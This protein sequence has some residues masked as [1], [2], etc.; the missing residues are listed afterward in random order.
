MRLRLAAP[1]LLAGTL[2]LVYLAWAPRA[3]DLAAQWFRTDLFVHEGLTIW[4]GHW[5]GGH[6]TPGY[7]LLFP[8]LSALLSPELVGALAAVV[9]AVLFQRIARRQW[10]TGAWVGAVWFTASAAA[11][12]YIGRLTFALGIAVGA[13]AVLAAQRGRRAVALALAA[14]CPLGSPVAGLFLA[15]LGVA[16][17]LAE[18]RRVGLAVAVAALVPAVAIALAFPDA[19]RQTF[20]AGTFW[21]LLVYAA[22]VLVFVPRT[23]R[24]QRL[25][26]VLYALAATAAFVLDTPMGSNVARLGTT[27][28]PPVL[29]CALWPQRRLVLAALAPALLFWQINPV[30]GDVAKAGDESTKAAYY[31]PL[32]RFLAAHTSPP[33]RVEVV[34]TRTHFEVVYVSE[35]FALAR[36][37][38]R[39]LDTRF[40]ELFYR[41]ALH[42]ASY[43]RWLDTLG[44]RYVALPDARLDFAGRREGRLVRAGLPYLR[45]VWKGR[46]WRVFAVAAPAP[47]AGGAARLARLGPTSFSVTADRPGDALVRVHYSPYWKVVAG[48]A[49]VQQGPDDLTTLRI[50]RAGTVRVTI[51]F[52]LD[53]VADRGVRC[54]RRDRAR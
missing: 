17:T 36:G 23:D 7:S 42:A 41:D 32:T 25:A 13:G 30:W 8:P 26:A 38:E 12:V 9:S 45:P 6:H 51:A 15:L 18:R 40:N 29:A 49:C 31:A 47:L 5:F 24:S 4:N 19:G 10:G 52:A 48:V 44:V 14:L 28:G 20:G 43:R 22:A 11:N 39:Q 21:P 2:A 33:G 16:H 46:H 34:P 35:R 1:W 27:L 3:P 37:W 50:A 54:R 53:R